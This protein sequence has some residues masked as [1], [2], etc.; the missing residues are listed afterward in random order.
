MKRAKIKKIIGVCSLLAAS[1]WIIVVCGLIYLTHGMSSFGADSIVYRDIYN[2]TEWFNLFVPSMYLILLF[3]DIFS[4]IS[5][6]KYKKLL[7]GI[8]IFLLVAQMASFSLILK[9][10]IILYILFYLFCTFIFW[11]IYYVV[12]YL[13]K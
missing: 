12:I 8:Q 3:L 9:T 1:M 6:R 7:I 11:G 13:D 5:L 4:I 10:T 2:Y